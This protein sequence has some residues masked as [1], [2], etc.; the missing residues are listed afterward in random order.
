MAEK[1]KTL[2][3]PVGETLMHNI[4]RIREGQRLTFVKLSEDLAEIG[5]PIPILGLRRIERGERR[6]DAEELLALAYVLGV[7]PV[8]LLVA[9]ELDDDAPY[10]IA[11]GVRATAGAARDWIGG[12]GFL[13]STDV[14]DMARALQWMPKSRQPLVAARWLQRTNAA[15]RDEQGEAPRRESDG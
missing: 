15:L 14:A 8:D 12:V 5:R 7:Q 2:I 11:P 10:S 13:P 1:Q 4:K 6:V 3:G 9:P